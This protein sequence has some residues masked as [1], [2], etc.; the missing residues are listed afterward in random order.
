MSLRAFGSHIHFNVSIRQMIWSSLRV[1]RLWVLVSTTFCVVI[2]SSSTHSS[3]IHNVLVPQVWSHLFC[4]VQLLLPTLFFFL[5]LF[6]LREIALQHLHNRLNVNNVIFTLTVVFHFLVWMTLETWRKRTQHGVLQMNWLF[7]TPHPGDG[8]FL[9]FLLFWTWWL[10][11]GVSIIYLKW[12]N[13]CCY[14]L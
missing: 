14:F 13:K 2:K 7:V 10:T 5:T 6:L 4:H 3:T 1:G 12:N 8:L 11:N 9:Y